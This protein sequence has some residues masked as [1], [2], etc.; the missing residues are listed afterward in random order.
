[1]WNVNYYNEN[2]YVGPFLQKAGITE[3]ESWLDCFWILSSPQ[4]FI[5]K[6]IFNSLIFNFIQIMKT[7]DQSFLL[8]LNYLQR[9][10]KRFKEKT[11]YILQFILYF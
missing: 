3:D 1:M 9:S 4:D 6:L 2:L 11:N 7:K 5:C 8:T 10:E